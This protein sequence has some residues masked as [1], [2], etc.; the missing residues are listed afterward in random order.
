[1]GAKTAIFSELR[2]AGWPSGGG[3]GV[4]G[5]SDTRGTHEGLSGDT[6][7]TPGGRSEDTRRTPGG[8]LDL[9]GT[10]GDSL[11]HSGSGGKTAPPGRTRGCQTAR[12]VEEMYEGRTRTEDGR[13]ASRQRGPV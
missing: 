12:H 10:A 8:R 4:G 1:M 2:P 3:P 7:G 13:P 9:S 5:T 11:G 6:W